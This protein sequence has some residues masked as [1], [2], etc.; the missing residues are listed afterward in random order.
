MRKRP[1]GVLLTC[2]L[3][4]G[5]L[6]ACSGLLYLGHQPTNG[7]HVDELEADLRRNVP[8]GS[9]RA[10]AEAWFMSHGWRPSLAGQTGTE[11]IVGI[12]TSVPNSSWLE[13][14]EIRIDIS[15]D[16]AGVI[17]AVSIYRF[18]FTL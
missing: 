15:F 11:R 6:A 10:Q 3:L 9:T 1:N 2:L 18:V 5:G 7:I 13:T 8:V 16:E 17:T 14:A 12:G 4:A